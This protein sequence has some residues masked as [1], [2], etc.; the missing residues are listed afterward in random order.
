MKDELFDF[1]AWF[2]WDLRKR[3]DAVGYVGWRSA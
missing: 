3:E 1:G 2:S